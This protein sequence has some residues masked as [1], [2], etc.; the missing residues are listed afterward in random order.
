MSSLQGKVADK[1]RLAVIG[2]T[3]NLGLGLALRWAQAGYP[4]SLGSRD[5]QRA[6]AAAER[7]SAAAGVALDGGGNAAVA[8]GADIVVVAVPYA[9]QG[10]TLA[11]IRD[12]VQGKIVVD[13]TVPLVPPKVMRVQL[14]AEGSAARRAQNLLGPQARVVS[15][16]QNIAA[17]H[18]REL[19]HP[20]EGDVLVSGDDAEAREAVVQLAQA[21]GLIA[22]H[23]GALD[24]AVV[25]EALTSVLIFMNKRYS[26]DGAGI[27][28]CGSR[29]DG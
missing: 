7:E 17:A 1:P 13:T 28:I 2:G 8:A 11:E 5:A 24:N 4:V 21:I 16:F 20:L 9:A 15:A 18:L 26:F 10:E 19:S 3:G 23:A 29:N 27:R 22:W 14:P 6:R 25:A 12:A